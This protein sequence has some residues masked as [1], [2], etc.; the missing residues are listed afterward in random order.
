[1]QAVRMPKLPLQLTITRLDDIDR[2]IIKEMLVNANTS[3][4]S[5]AKKYAIPLSTVQRR[6]AKIEASSLLEH[7]Y[8]L[9][10]KALNLRVIELYILAEKGKSDKIAREI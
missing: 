4:R 8:K 6:R 7:T 2:N 9:N 1:M 10:P 3:S 5:I